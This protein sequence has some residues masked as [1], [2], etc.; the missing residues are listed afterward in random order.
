MDKSIK[1]LVTS[2]VMILLLGLGFMSA[3]LPNS[4]PSL[5]VQQQKQ[6]SAESSQSAVQGI[7]GERAFVTEVVDGDTIRV[8]IGLQEYTVRY[9]GV[10]TPE[11]RDPR[12][13]V[14]C[15]GK[16]ASQKN[17]ELVGNKIVIL[18]RDISETD[19]YDRLLRYIYLPLKNGSYLFVND[20]LIRKGYA[21]AL[22]Y[23]PDLKFAEQFRQAE[24]EA[25][26]NQNGLWSE[27]KR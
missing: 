22:T 12:R 17:K 21:Y 7:E 3:N 24:Q 8:V 5:D 27:C 14:E 15:F 20:Y 18:Q 2:V 26:H 1:V 13:S 25:K 10:D 6:N 23:P 9:I 11:T 4:N 19:K 16:Q